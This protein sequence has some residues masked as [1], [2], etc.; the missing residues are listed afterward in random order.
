[1]VLIFSEDCERTTDEV[2]Q[3]LISNGKKF[4]R[5]NREDEVKIVNISPTK[6]V[7]EVEVNGRVYDLCQFS[8][9]WYRRGSLASNCVKASLAEL[10]NQSYTVQQVGQFLSNEWKILQHYIFF[11][12]ERK[13]GALGS[14]SKSFINKPIVLTIAKECGLSIPETVISGKG[15]ILYNEALYK[16]LIT[17]PISEAE[18]FRNADGSS[19]KLL[20]TPI[21][22][23]TFDKNSEFF[24]SLIQHNI[25]KWIELRVFFLKDSFYSMAIFSQNN[26]RTS[27]DFR[28]YDD[29]KPNR[30]VPFLL[31]KH[32]EKQ[33]G[34]LM[35][36][37]GLDTGSIDM[38]VTPQKEYFFLEVNPIGNIEMVSKNCN[39]PIEMDIAKYLAYEKGREVIAQ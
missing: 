22:G 33:L 38:I 29:E 34:N 8:Q 18:T 1:M 39:Y 30:M 37:L 14:F 16:P 6:G 28:N 26:S 20:T 10:G 11:V 17:K 7:I 25:E 32:I 12:M 3:W 21:E 5:I 4:L 31:P 27:I 13:K 36:K 15:S 23:T 2:A 9:V 19:S 35:D 24:P